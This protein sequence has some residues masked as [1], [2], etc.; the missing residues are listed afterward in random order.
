M[1]KAIFISKIRDLEHATC[2]YNRLYFGNEF[3]ERLIPGEDDL[4]RAVRHCRIN[5]LHFSLVTPYMTDKGLNLCERLFKWLVTHKVNCE[6]I[7]NDY[8]GLDLINRKFEI[9]QP[10]LGR[11][12]C[13]QKKD[14]RIALLVK[15]G[16]KR[17]IFTKKEDKYILAI[18]TKI[19]ETLVSYFRETVT[20]VRLFQRYLANW[21]IRRV[22]LDNLLQG[23]NV[24]F[25][26]ERLAGSLYFPYAYITT[27][28]RCSANPFHKFRPFSSRILFC[29]KRMPKIYHDFK[30]RKYAETFI[31]E[32][33]HRFF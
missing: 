29:K 22:E 24:E 25:P 9:L 10:V 30:K 23:I 11:L 14:P 3:C 6:V 7:I 27:T 17:T 5:G 2:K 28:R 8:G 16:A 32:R 13:K 4:A 1:E 12:L 21:R 18:P 19:P 31:Q 26:R 20:N 33:K 15:D